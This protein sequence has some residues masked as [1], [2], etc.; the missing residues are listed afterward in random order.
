M[1]TKEEYTGILKYENLPD[2]PATL[3]FNKNN[4]IKICIKNFCTKEQLNTLTDETIK[5]AIFV[6]ETKSFLFEIVYRYNSIPFNLYAEIVFESPDK[7]F[8]WNNFEITNIQF[9]TKYL[10]MFFKRV[11]IGYDNSEELKK[12]VTS[13]DSF[14][15]CDIKFSN[16]NISIQEINTPKNDTQDEIYLTLTVNNN[17]LSIKETEELIFNTSLIFDILTGFSNE[18]NNITINQSIKLHKIKYNLDLEEANNWTSLFFTVA[19][20]ENH[21]NIIFIN[22]FNN[23]NNFKETYKHIWAIFNSSKQSFYEYKFFTL[24]SMLDS[25]VSVKIKEN[26]IDFYKD[27]KKEIRH[28]LKSKLDTF[29]SSNIIS[30][31][32]LSIEEYKEI[33]EN[34]VARCLEGNNK[35]YLCKIKELYNTLS[36]TT[37]RIIDFNDNL[38]ALLRDSRN[39]IAHAN[40]LPKEFHEKFNILYYKTLLFICCLIWKDLGLDDKTIWNSLSPYTNISH[41]CNQEEL[42]HYRNLSKEKNLIK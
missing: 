15:K 32:N 11:S 30:R 8:D 7:N 6:T 38:L 29:D 22:F 3:I 10:N 17:T 39:A 1:D 20:L 27:E 34:I 28:A 31:N 9:T 13:Y 4:H 25:I 26:K 33:K 40:K 41:N 36:D 24:F 14:L 18:A 12:A 2:I 5:T 42:K 21:L 19:E 23:L 37:R 16:K 35:P